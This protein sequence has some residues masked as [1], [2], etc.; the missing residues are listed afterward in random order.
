MVGDSNLGEEVPP[1]LSKP[2][3]TNKST[4][5][6]GFIVIVEEIKDLIFDFLWKIGEAHR[7]PGRGVSLGA[8]RMSGVPPNL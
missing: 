2:R 8:V 5:P 7:G 1:A 3:A 6:K 4:T